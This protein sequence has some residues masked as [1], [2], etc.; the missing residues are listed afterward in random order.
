MAVLL[1][2]GDMNG[3]QRCWFSY[4]YSTKT[5]FH[6][7]RAQKEQGGSVPL[8]SFHV[9]AATTLLPSVVRPQA[10]SEREYAVIKWRWQLLVLQ[11]SKV[12]HPDEAA[13]ITNDQSCFAKK[14]ESD[15][16]LF[17]C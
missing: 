16:E 3:L 8:T 1:R 13:K 7:H 6:L 9:S 4:V 14:S 17:I 11:K 12:H 5:H 2:K 10:G 15:F